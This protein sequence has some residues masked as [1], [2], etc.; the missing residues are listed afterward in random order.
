MLLPTVCLY[1]IFKG[2]LQE[3]NVDVT[4]YSIAQKLTNSIL[5]TIRIQT[6]C[7]DKQSFQKPLS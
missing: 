5:I 7:H 1:V 6:Q 3:F 4:F 2:K